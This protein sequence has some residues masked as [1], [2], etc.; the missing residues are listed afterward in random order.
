MPDQLDLFGEEPAP[1]AAPV[2]LGDAEVYVGTS[3]YT[4]PDWRGRF[5]PRGLK[6]KDELPFYA[7][8]FP[9]VELNFSYYRI[10]EPKTLAGMLART[11]ASFRFVVKAY[12]G[13]THEPEGP[14]TERAFRESLSPLREAGR[15]AAVLAQFP[16][17][18][19]DSAESRARLKAIRE[20]LPEDKI[21]VEFR[22]RSWSGGDVLEFLEREDL[23]YCSVDEPELP[24]LMPGVCAATAGLGY[25][26]LHSR[27]ASKWH[28]G[29]AARYDYNYSDEELRE[30]ARKI[31]AII[32]KV[33]MVYVFFNN[34]SRGQ[35]AE[36]A[37]RF[38]GLLR[39]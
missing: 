24:E 10:P 5:Y 21:A 11:P 28:A 35:A 27:D 15:L 25:V 22:H 13:L 32:G 36:N 14:E 38:A 1:P 16:G 7:R 30:W 26:R 8:K 33:P 23:A 12:R 20:A 18:F 3:G 9:A 19:R 6:Q 2:R 4:F 34:C 17:S 39:A 29:G 31:A 37:G